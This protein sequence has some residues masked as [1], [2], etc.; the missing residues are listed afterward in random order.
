MK[1]Q[2]NYLFL[3]A[4]SSANAPSLNDAI[5][6]TT[7]DYSTAANAVSET[8]SYYQLLGHDYSGGLKFKALSSF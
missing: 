3:S 5:F 7:L 4:E 1:T 6:L 8:D 2:S